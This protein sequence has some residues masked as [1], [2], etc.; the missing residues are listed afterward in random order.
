MPSAFGA[1][2]LTIIVAC[3]LEFGA[4]IFD[5]GWILGEFWWGAGVLGAG[6]GALGVGFGGFIVSSN[7]RRF[8]L[9]FLGCLC[10]FCEWF[11]CRRCL[12]VFGCSNSCLFLI[13]GC[14]GFVVGCLCLVWGCLWVFK[15]LFG[16]VFWLNFSLLY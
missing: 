4:R 16:W 7:A 1:S 12:S 13:W 2:R 15:Q 6:F 8:Q 9:G 10:L 3:F 5:L 14:W 11:R